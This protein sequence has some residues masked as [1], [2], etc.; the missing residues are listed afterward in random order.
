M[1]RALVIVVTRIILPCHYNGS[2]IDTLMF[3]VRKI[4]VYT[5]YHSGRDTCEQKPICSTVSMVC[6]TAVDLAARP[7]GA[8]QA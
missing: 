6:G 8:D 2:A 1:D 5:T 3:I 4:F 7:K